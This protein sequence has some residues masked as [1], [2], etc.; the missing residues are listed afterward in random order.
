MD[1]VQFDPHADRDIRQIEK[2]AKTGGLRYGIRT[3]SQDPDEE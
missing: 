2:G 3:G 1:V